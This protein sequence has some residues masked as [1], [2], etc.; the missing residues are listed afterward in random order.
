MKKEY[1]LNKVWGADAYGEDNYIE[2]YM[3]RLRKVLKNLKS[4]TKILTVRG[5]GYKIVKA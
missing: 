5:L 1:L 2:V 4:K 3:S